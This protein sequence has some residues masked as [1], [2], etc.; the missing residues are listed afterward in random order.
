MSTSPTLSEMEFPTFDLPSP[1]PPAPPAPPAPPVPTQ[2]VAPGIEPHSSAVTGAT[3]VETPKMTLKEGIALAADV[4][5]AKCTRDLATSPTR[6]IIEFNGTKSAS[7]SVTSA[8]KNQGKAKPQPN[9]KTKA[10]QK[11]CRYLPSVNE[12]AFIGPL[13]DSPEDTIALIQSQ[14]PSFSPSKGVRADQISLK[15]RFDGGNSTACR[16]VLF[17]IMPGCWPDAVNATMHL[18]FVDG[19]VVAPA[20]NPKTVGSSGIGKAE[21]NKVISD[22]SDLNVS[23][24]GKPAA[25]G[26]TTASGLVREE[27]GWIPQEWQQD[28]SSDLNLG[29]GFS[30]SDNYPLKTGARPGHKTGREAGLRWDVSRRGG[31]LLGDGENCL[32]SRELD[33]DLDRDADSDH[34][35]PGGNS[36]DFGVIASRRNFLPA[37]TTSSSPPVRLIDDGRRLAIQWDDLERD[38]A[39]LG[40]HN[41]PLDAHHT[42]S[43]GPSS[44]SYLITP[45]SAFAKDDTSS[46]TF[47]ADPPQH[48]QGQQGQMPGQRQ[49][50]SQ[51]E[52]DELKRAGTFLGVQGRGLVPPTNPKSSG[53]QAQAL[54]QAPPH[55]QATAPSSH[56]Y[57][58]KWDDLKRGG[59]S[60]GIEGLTDFAA[61]VKK[62]RKAA[63]SSSK[64]LL[65]LDLGVEGDHDM[66]AEANA[67]SG[68][69]LQT[70][71]DKSPQIPADAGDID[72]DD[73]WERMRRDGISLGITRDR[74]D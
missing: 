40:D 60:L 63:M 27:K 58:T 55:P 65:D 18:V 3:A 62:E 36:G 30:F 69:E 9:L 16:D 73:E 28:L 39:L 6:L 31:L 66:E 32:D 14:C 72:V 49:S 1:P 61:A 35:G 38:G 2:A 33:L 34:D 46:T 57:V 45:S 24:K 44:N 43:Y 52:W 22:P 25:T 12:E 4:R 13:L 53:A 54:A 41:G 10:Q 67:E 68:A 50:Q 48:R 47:I 29:F 64:P 51:A 26:T 71:S 59:I 37:T 11:Y 70:T 5:N 21:G 7:T 19:P 17:R 74:D 15:I 42:L 23:G 20:S 56:E 8:K